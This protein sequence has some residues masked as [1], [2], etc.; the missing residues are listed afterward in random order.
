MT[1]NLITLTIRRRPDYFRDTGINPWAIPIN[2]EV[3]LSVTR[4]WQRAH[5]DQDITCRV[6]VAKARDGGDC[7]V[8]AIDENGDDVLLTE[9]EMVQLRQRAVDGEDETGR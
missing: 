7:L 6:D 2:S 5:P 3:A 9:A 4:A 8:E 1:K